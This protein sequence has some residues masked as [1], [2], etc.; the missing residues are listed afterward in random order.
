ML[1]LFS[2]FNCSLIGSWTYV[3]T[4]FYCFKRL[5]FGVL[6]DCMYLQNT[7][8]HYNTLQHAATRCN[9]L[10]RSTLTW[11]WETQDM[12]KEEAH[13]LQ[14]TATRKRHIYY[15]TLQQGRGTYTT[16]HCRVTYTTTHLCCQ[17]L[18][19]CHW[20]CIESH[21]NATNSFLAGFLVVESSRRALAV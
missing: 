21:R 10:Q 8:T 3:E 15:N 12:V 18:V 5:F 7:A 4:L 20:P 9:T 2:T 16:T 14:H 1:R 19:I 13:M 17:C 11:D 6:R